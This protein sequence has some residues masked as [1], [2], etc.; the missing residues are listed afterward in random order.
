MKKTGILS[1]I[2]FMILRGF[3]QPNSGFENWAQDFSAESPVGWQTLNFLTFTTPPNPVSV[4]K[5]SGIDK[6]SGNYAL[7]LKTVYIN[8]NLAPQILDDTMG[9]IF[10]GV[11]NIS[12]AYYR[13]GFPYNSRPA[14]LTV[15]H[16]YLPVGA[17]EA[18]IRVIMTK[19]NGIKRDTIVLSE[20]AMTEQDSYS[21]FEMD[22]DYL[23][24]DV[25]DTATILIGSSRHRDVARVGS[26]LYIDDI[27]F[28]GYVGEKEIKSFDKVKVFPNPARDYLYITACP[29]NS[30]TAI[31]TDLSGNT[32]GEYKVEQKN[33]RIDIH[34][35]S[36]G[37]YFYQ[38][39][40]KAQNILSRGKVNITN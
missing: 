2:L 19:W 29:D 26:V 10:T 30:E 39:N 31:L 32:V 36:S 12:P 14:K 13:Y 11:V 37:I 33:V 40:D 27:A 23:T 5:V 15:W 25:P 1:F 20:K 35:L 4:T 6:H 16:K 24:N 17:D 38:I 7:R 28:T 22:I 18:G 21:L 9:A 34:C 3:S 8:N